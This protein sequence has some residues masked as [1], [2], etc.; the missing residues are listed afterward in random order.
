MFV[1]GEVCSAFTK[2]S[3]TCEVW[4]CS[5]A[6]FNALV[7]SEVMLPFFFLPFFSP[8]AGDGDTQ[9]KKEIGT[10]VDLPNENNQRKARI[11]THKMQNTDGGGGCDKKSRIYVC[12]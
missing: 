8:A 12:C 4:C 3:K 10:A 7:D 5:C 1:H 6:Q 9:K 2:I 11:N